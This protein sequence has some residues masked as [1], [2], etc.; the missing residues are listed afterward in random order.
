LRHF[1]G[2]RYF[3]HLVCRGQ[4]CCETSYKALDHLKNN[5][6]IQNINNA[7]A[8]KI[9][10][11]ENKTGCTGRNLHISR[12]IIHKCPREEM[13]QLPFNWLMDKQTGAQSYN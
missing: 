1:F 6:L 9:L 13:T 11:W 12:S 8:E 4:G 3:W 7:D 2:S 10:A 5:Y